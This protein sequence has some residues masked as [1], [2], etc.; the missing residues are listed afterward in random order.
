MMWKAHL[1]DNMMADGVNIYLLFEGETTRQLLQLDGDAPRME[2]LSPADPVAQSPT[3]AISNDAARALLEALLRYYEGSADSHTVRADMIH[4]RAR[5]DK[6]VDTLLG[7][8]QA[9]VGMTTDA[10]RSGPQ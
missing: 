7:V 9:G 3:L 8:M 10:Y 5:Y 2:V 4:M 6:V 1:S